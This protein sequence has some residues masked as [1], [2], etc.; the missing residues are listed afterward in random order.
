VRVQQSVCIE[1][2]IAEVYAF[3]TDLPLVPRWNRGLERVTLTSDLP[4]Q[5]GA[6]FCEV[7]R[8]FGRRIAMTC[9]VT[10][11][12]PRK[13]F[14]YRSLAGPYPVTMTWTFEP[15]AEGTRFRY[16]SD[17]NPGGVY[18]WLQPFLVR[19]L[20]RRL[21]SALRNLKGILEDARTVGNRAGDLREG[22]Q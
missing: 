6:T 3:A 16:A 19:L 5:V 12:E 15:V 8:V 11:I 14:R 22:A 1:R 7:A 17:A 2:P 18:K 9:E 10:E 21:D 20:Q 13:L 4:V